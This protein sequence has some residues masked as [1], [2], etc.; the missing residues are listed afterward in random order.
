MS[1]IQ[2][3]KESLELLIP[4]NLKP[5]L[6]VTLKT[7]MDIYKSVN[8][9]LTSRGNWIAAV[10]LI[11]LIG[12]TNI[13]KM[14]HLF[15]AQELLLNSVHHFLFFIFLLA[16][17]PSIDIKDRIYFGHYLKQYWYFVLVSIAFGISHL[18]V[19]PF[20]FIIYMVFLLFVFDSYGSKNELIL[21][22]KNSVKMVVFN[23]PIFLILLAVLAIINIIVY[24][25]V[26]FA[27]GY[28]GGLT[29]AVLIYILFVPIQVAFIS[30]LYIK[31]IHGQSSLYFKQ[32]E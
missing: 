4:Q 17:R 30:N 15:W 6:L 9:P 7:V 28:F 13:I 29:L 1:L 19:I 2:S 8:K 21:A 18:Y 16:M 22:L 31:F 23:F 26:A 24:Y 5:F 11:M 3:W 20:A 14:F 32:P 12:L 10:I 27:L 25:L